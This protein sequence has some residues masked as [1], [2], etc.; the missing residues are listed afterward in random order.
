[1]LHLLK[2]SVGTRDPADL[3]AWQAA[4]AVDEPPL[5]HRTRMRPK[6]A[7]EIADGGSIYWV[8]AGRL[9]VRQRVL[10]IVDDVWDDG[11]SCAGILL[12]PALVEVEARPVQPFQGWRYLSPEAAPGDLAARLAGVAIDPDLPDEMRR[13]LRDLCLL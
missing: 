13:Q 6:R 4:R 7:A 1:M 3:R 5:R 12:D 11:S 10:D 9:L 8:I 2:L